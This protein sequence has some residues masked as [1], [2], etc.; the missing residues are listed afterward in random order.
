MSTL[1]TYFMMIVLVIGIS[2]MAHAVDVTDVTRAKSF[3]KTLRNN[4]RNPDSFSLLSVG[5]KANKNKDSNVC[6]TFRAQNGL[7]GMNVVSAVLRADGK[8]FSSDDPYP[9]AALSV[10]GQCNT[11]QLVDITDQVTQ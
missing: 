1:K 7:G 10:T 6:V 3:V 5:T 8:I 4:T 2:T 9:Y 11:K